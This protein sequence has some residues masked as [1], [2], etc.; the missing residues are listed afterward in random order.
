MCNNRTI[1]CNRNIVLRVVFFKDATAQGGRIYFALPRSLFCGSVRAQA[2]SILGLSA[3]A[4]ILAQCGC[5]DSGTINA[6]RIFCC[7][8]PYLFWGTMPHRL[9]SGKGTNADAPILSRGIVASFLVAKCGQQALLLVDIIPSGLPICTVQNPS[10]PAC[11]VAA[12]LI[13]ARHKPAGAMPI[14]NSL[15]LLGESP[16]GFWSSPRARKF[17][18]RT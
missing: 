18:R 9:D 1:I 6:G 5:I 3:A 4:S 11:H 7:C 12:K 2:A 14:Q 8:G 17:L 10:G 13:T 15:L 16:L